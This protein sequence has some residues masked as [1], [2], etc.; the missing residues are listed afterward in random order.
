MPTRKGQDLLAAVALM[1]M[2]AVASTL[3]MIRID[4]SQRP[5][6]PTLN[7][8]PLGYTLS[9]A[10]FVIPCMVFGVWLW[11]SPRTAEQR[12]ACVITLILLIPLGFILDVF[13]GRMF[14]RF[15]NLDATLGI[16]I[17]G[18]DLR[19]GWRGLSGSGWEPFLPVEEFAFYGL[20][21]VAMLL[22]YIWGDAILFRASKVDDRQRTPR[23]F[24]GW[25]AT[26]LGSVLIW[27]AAAGVEG[28]RPLN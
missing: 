13:F 2:L 4:V 19:T 21:F 24:R 9:L 26:L 5:V 8:S 20:G 11:R 7:P 18:Y 12:R 25:K 6:D 28:S 1:A 27:S 14:L 23:V 15:P 17:P 10:L 16:L 3:A 22:A